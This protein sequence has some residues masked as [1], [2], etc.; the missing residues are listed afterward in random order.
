MAEIFDLDL[1][2]SGLFFVTDRK[3][4]INF[5]LFE[6][7]IHFM[8]IVDFSF[9]N[10]SQKNFAFESIQSSKVTFR[11]KYDIDSLL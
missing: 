5:F 6:K 1:S 11:N 3:Y 4:L 7:K 10:K 9:V 2:V 8:C